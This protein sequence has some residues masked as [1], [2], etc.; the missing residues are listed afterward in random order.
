MSKIPPECGQAALK[1]AGVDRQEV[2][3][4]RFGHALVLLR[5]RAIYNGEMAQFNDHRG[6][7]KR[8]SEVQFPDPNKLVLES[9]VEMEW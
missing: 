9:E 1:R 5:H 3:V 7:A 8:S 2:S 6:R 4:I